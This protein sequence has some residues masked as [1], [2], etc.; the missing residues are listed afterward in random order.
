P[1]PPNLGL[2]PGPPPLGAQVQ[3][4]PPPP[5]NLGL[6][7]GPPQAGARLQGG[8]PPPGP[9]PARQAAGAT[10]SRPGAP[11][12]KQT[13]ASRAFRDKVQPNM[14]SNATGLPDGEIA[15]NCLKYNFAL[16]NAKAAGV[17]S[18]A[19]LPKLVAAGVPQQG[20]T[21]QVDANQLDPL[22]DVVWA[23]YN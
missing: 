13:P 23:E 6:P 15:A 10:L 11:D 3:G 9:G 20:G 5:P 8:P 21:G 16:K 19:L 22:T 18:T 2:P 14:I 4:G 1:P 7:P 17:D 12:P